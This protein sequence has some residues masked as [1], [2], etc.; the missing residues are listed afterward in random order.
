MTKSEWRINDE[1]RMS[2]PMTKPEC[3]FNDEIRM[4]NGELVMIA[5]A[6]SL[7]RH[8]S[9]LHWVFGFP[10]SPQSVPVYRPDARVPGRPRSPRDV[11]DAFCG[12]LW[13]FG[14]R[15][16]RGAANGTCL[17]SIWCSVTT[18][19]KT[20]QHTRHAR[21]REKAAACERG[22]SAAHLNPS[23]AHAVAPAFSLSSLSLRPQG[24]HRYPVAAELS[25]GA[26]Q[27]P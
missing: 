24:I 22:T 16:H 2:I 10:H 6:T 27:W 20:H 13:A 9:F 4:A 14:T 25:P 11:L 18:G 19:G 7:I 23:T 5:D 1:I 8:S 3:R 17:A 26:R 12:L 15:V 21:S